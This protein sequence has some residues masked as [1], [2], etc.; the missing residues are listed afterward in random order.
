MPKARPVDAKQR[1]LRAHGTLHPR[2]AR[3][4]DELFQ[5]AGFFDPRD[6]VQVKYEMLRRVR[7]EG[8]SITEAA[9]RF[10]FSRPSFYKAHRAFEREGLW[11]L[12]PAKRGPRR[13][14]KLSAEVMA[15]IAL[16]RDEDPSLTVEQLVRVLRKE[17]Q[18]RVHP[19]SLER[20]LARAVK[21]TP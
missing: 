9:R 11:G 15:F 10:A 18:L 14:H 4:T 3:V 8:L 19:R 21:K 1:S 17:R 2:P 5:G 12:L 7:V 13:S 16:R 20:A 6:L